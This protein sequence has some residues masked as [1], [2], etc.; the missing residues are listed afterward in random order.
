MKDALSTVLEELCWDNLHSIEYKLQAVG[1]F[2]L[3]GCQVTNF[4]SNTEKSE[5][6]LMN[7]TI[8]AHNL[9]DYSHTI[10]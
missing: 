9:H 4:S 5:C 10:T 1:A 7:S 2:D 3:Y 8:F 6:Q